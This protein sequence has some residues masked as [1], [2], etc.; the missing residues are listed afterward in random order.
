MAMKKDLGNQSI[1]SVYMTEVIGSNIEDV[2]TIT[3]NFDFSCLAESNLLSG[4]VKLIAETKGIFRSLGILYGDKALT[5][6]SFAPYIT[7]SFDV[8]TNGTEKHSLDT[9]EESLLKIMAILK[10][11]DINDYKTLMSASKVCQLLGRYTQEV[12]IDSFKTFILPVEVW[13]SETLKNIRSEVKRTLKAE[14][15]WDKKLV[16]F[17]EKDV[18]PDTKFMNSSLSIARG[19]MID[20]LLED[21]AIPTSRI[22]NLDKARDVLQKVANYIPKEAVDICNW[23][24]QDFMSMSNA[25][26]LTKKSIIESLNG[27][28][29]DKLSREMIR[30]LFDPYYQGQKN[31]LRKMLSALGL[32]DSNIMGRVWAAYY[33]SIQKLDAKDGSLPEGESESEVISSLLEKL[34]KE[35]LALAIF[36]DEDVAKAKLD[37]C[38]IPDGTEVEF[39]NHTAVYEEYAA[40]GI[41][42]PDGVYTIQEYNGNFLAVKNVKAHLLEQLAEQ[43][44]QSTITI[45]VKSLNDGDDEETLAKALNHFATDGVFLRDYATI[46]GTKTVVYDA[47]CD[48][49]GAPI[50]KFEFPVEGWTKELKTLIKVRAFEGKYDVL[51]SNTFMCGDY[52]KTFLLLS[53]KR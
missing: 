38:T 49:R 26:A 36:S 40:Y 4:D 14:I 33:A 24:Q 7:V 25:A 22:Q 30:D 20:N 41:S 28:V 13:E 29:L 16:N 9:S 46:P 21:L 2:G 42:I 17:V 1:T 3:N 6:E 52:K 23:M 50:G 45:R 10:E 12:G 15:E 5:M 32:K 31:L 8:H 11:G 44:K 43:E 51:R 35:E 48:K 34:L 37:F 53:R 18:N 27:D 19:E 39:K 47:I